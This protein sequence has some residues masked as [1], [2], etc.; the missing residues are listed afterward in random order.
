MEFTVIY[1]LLKFWKRYIIIQFKIS[2][3][4]QYFLDNAYSNSQNNYLLAILAY[5]LKICL[6]WYSNKKSENFVSKIRV[7][8]TSSRLTILTIMDKDG[9]TM[10]TYVHIHIILKSIIYPFKN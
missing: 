2:A 10:G 6:K 1:R 4:K 8:T 5:Y 7:K 9:Y 3:I